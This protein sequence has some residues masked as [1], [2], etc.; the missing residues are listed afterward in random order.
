EESSEAVRSRVNAAR[1]LQRARY[2]AEGLY[3]N[4]QLDSK[5]IRIYCALGPEANR[6]LMMATQRYRLTAR[7]HFRVLRVARTLADLEG[8][9]EIQESHIAEALRYR[10]LDAKYWGG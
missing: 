10:M 9:G 3:A 6:V 1:A 7:A 2:A 8:A 5:R 4:A